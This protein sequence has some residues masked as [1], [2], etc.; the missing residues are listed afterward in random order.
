MSLNNFL[1]QIMSKVYMLVAEGFECV[2][3]LAP[4]DVLH[5]AGVQ[6]IRVAVSS[7]L[8]VVSS[9]NL[10]RLECD[11]LLAD[12]DMSDGD[13]LILPGGNPGY[14]NLGASEGVRAAV[15]DFYGSGRIVAAI[16]GAP[17]VLALA[18]VARGANITCHSSV[19]SR[20]D[21]YDYH[22]EGVV[23]YGNLITAAGAGRSIEFALA[24]ARRLVGSDTIAAVCQG[25]EL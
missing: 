20:M 7:D 6:V 21:G 4:I 3:T 2:E 14:I 24:I 13:A 16:C 17:T 19:V 8:S 25:M 23:E 5:R 11:V 18:D 9:H 1:L 15:R 22:R 10:M 12:V